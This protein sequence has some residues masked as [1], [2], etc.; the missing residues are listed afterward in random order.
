MKQEQQIYIQ[1][2]KSTTRFHRVPEISIRNDHFSKSRMKRESLMIQTNEQTK[3]S[4]F[5]SVQRMP[6]KRKKTLKL[7][8]L[9][10]KNVIKQDE[11]EPARS[12]YQCLHQGKATC[13]LGMCQI[14]IHKSKNGHY[15]HT[16]HKLFF[17]LSFSPFFEG[18]ISCPANIKERAFSPQEN[19][20]P[21]LILYAKRVSG[22][23]QGE[24]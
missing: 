9:R 8:F 22:E 24:T 7:L 12:V 20:S 13:L 1:R 5:F 14:Y 2:A 10:R 15:V 21:L 6:K 11:E 23:G 17:A 16:S 19:R 3:Q 4:E 18:S